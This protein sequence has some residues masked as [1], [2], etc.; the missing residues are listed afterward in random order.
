MAPTCRGHGQLRPALLGWQYR[1]SW[2]A[3]E[4]SPWWFAFGRRARALAFLE[5]FHPV[6]I[7]EQVR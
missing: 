6:W 4:W 2:S 1:I 7:E 3:L 5:R